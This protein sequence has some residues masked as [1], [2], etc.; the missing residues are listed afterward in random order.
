MHQVFTLVNICKRN[1]YTLVSARNYQTRLTATADKL[2]LNI[3]RT[4]YFTVSLRMLFDMILRSMKWNICER[5]RFLCAK[6]FFLCSCQWPETWFVWYVLCVSQK[7][8]IEFYFTHSF[9]VLSCSCR[10]CRVLFDGIICLV[11]GIIIMAAA[12]AIHTCAMVAWKG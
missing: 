6:P 8:K 4:S 2:E 12:P 9:G 5:D 1:T 7:K 11:T 10:S 3:F